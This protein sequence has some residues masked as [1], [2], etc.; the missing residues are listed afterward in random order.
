MDGIINIYKEKGYTSFDVVAKLRGIFHQKKIGHTGTLD[1][2]AT[3]VLPVCLG[4]ATK[5]CDVLTDKD[6]S[7]SAVARLGII[8]DTQ[9][10]WGNVLE[11]RD[12]NVSKAALEAA[13]EKFRGEISQVPPM[14]SAIK[15]GGK[16]LYELAR[17]GIEV[18]RKAR[19]VKILDSKVYDF[20]EN[21]GTFSLDVTCSKGTYIRTLIHDIGQELGCG[22]TMTALERTRVDIFELES[23][24][25]LDKVQELVE[26]GKILGH[27]LPIDEALNQYD[28]MQVMPEDDKLLHNGN[29]IDISR[30]NMSIKQGDILRIYDSEGVFVA[31]YYCQKAGKLIKN[32]KM[33]MI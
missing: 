30:Y 9:D 32:K 33:F 3:G 12:F 31:L 29:P 19:T 13:V 25:K 6:K 7:Y 14:Y 22:A 2:D 10:I 8:T 4:R 23:A 21:S 26:E 1:P 11:I 20:D 18:E 5:I 17:Q 24:M 28:K 16:R 15:V 27:I